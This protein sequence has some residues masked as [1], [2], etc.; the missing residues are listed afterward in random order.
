MTQTN[1]QVLHVVRR[2]GPVGGMERYVWELTHELQQLGHQVTVL[3]ERCYAEKPVT[4]T[5]HE[6][7]EITKRPRWLAQWRFSGRVSRWLLDHPHPGWLIHSHERLNVHQITTF[8]G[9]PFATILERPFWH[10]LSLRVLARL[11]LEK[12]EL[13]VA[14]AIVP[15]SIFIKEQLAR[16]YLDYAH[17]LVEPIVPGVKPSVLRPFRA[18]PPQGGIVGFVGKEWQ[19]K[20]LPLAVEIAAHLRQS[21]PDLELWVI[22]PEPQEVQHLFSGWRGGFR[23][24]GWHSDNEYLKEID[25]LLHPAKAEPYGMV[26][27]EA[28]A[29]CVPVVISDV[30]GAATQVD[31]EAGTVLSLRASVK[32]WGEAMEQQLNREDAPPKYVHGWDQ[33][34]KKQETAYR[35]LKMDAG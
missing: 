20:G 30:C 13:A 24:L 19:R 1:L 26:I 22:G 9:P 27:S 23:L 14:Q 6:L 33:V 35:Q 34:A 17:K 32:I 12:R 16:Y 7:G 3:C 4:I 31:E 28:M 8:H 11:Y 5:V 18:V 29:A 25:V 2:Y 21:R 15:N 10:W